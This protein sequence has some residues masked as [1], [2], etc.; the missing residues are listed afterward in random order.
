MTAEPSGALVDRLATYFERGGLD[1]VQA[2]QAAVELFSDPKAL[3]ELG[4][5]LV[6]L[7]QRT[8]APYPID[9]PVRRGPEAPE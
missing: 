4:R 2:R 9:V 6:E 7:G 1:P 5:E 3:A 8:D